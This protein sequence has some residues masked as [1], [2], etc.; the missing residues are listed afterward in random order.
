M[1]LKERALRLRD[2]DDDA[3]VLVWPLRPDQPNL[4]VNEDGEDALVLPNDLDTGRHTLALG[5]ETYRV[6]VPKTAGGQRIAVAQEIHF[7]DEIATHSA[8]RTVMPLLV[9]VPILVITGEAGLGKTRFAAQIERMATAYDV[10]SSR[11]TAG[12]PSS[13]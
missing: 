2:R 10:T 12:V 3:R 4:S 6:V 11:F 7:R 5:H 1:T 9:F 13:S 8:F